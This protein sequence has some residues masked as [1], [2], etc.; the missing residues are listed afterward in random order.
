MDNQRISNIYQSLQ[1]SSAQYANKIA[2]SFEGHNYS[3]QQFHQQV[4]TSAK[5]MQYHYQIQ[6]GDI[7]VLALGNRP[8]FCSLFYAA[9]ALGAIVVPLSTK[10][11]ADDSMSVLKGINAKIVFFDPAY[12]PWLNKEQGVSS[13]QITLSDWQFTLRNIDNHLEHKPVSLAQVSGEDIAAIIYTSGTTGKA[14]G[15]VISH[16]N[17]LSAIQAYIDVLQLTE[18]DSTILPIPI[19]HITGL[20]ALLC[21]FIHIGGTIYLHNRFQASEILDAVNKQQI[22]FIHGSPTVFILLI[23]E[24]KRRNELSGYPSL[25][26]IA[27]GAGHLNSGVIQQLSEVFPYAE[28]RPIYGLT[29]TTSP[30][31][32]F[33]HDVRQSNKQGSSGLAVPGLEFKICD[34]RNNELPKNKPGHLW[35]KGPMVINHYWQNPSINQQAFSNEWF[36]TGDIACIDEDNYLY[37]KDRSKDMI[38]RGG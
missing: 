26:M 9:M 31:S 4:E 29:E 37:I 17:V 32:I 28:I 8:E 14:K 13:H 7:I 16:N 25:R 5:C 12:Q 34:D 1:S 19:C 2:L 36:Y 38:N 27:C 35:L 18:K 24:G 22:T 3:Y 15:A 33:P 23:Q 6:K 10:L 20:S 11:K 21:L 30:A